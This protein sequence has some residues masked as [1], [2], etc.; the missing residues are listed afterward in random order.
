MKAFTVGLFWCVLSVS[1]TY[2]VLTDRHREEMGRASADYDIAKNAAEN[3]FK[4]LREKYDTL[5]EQCIA[6]EEISWWSSLWDS[7]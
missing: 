6:Q 4:M 2:L 5:S 1:I 7:K 3:R